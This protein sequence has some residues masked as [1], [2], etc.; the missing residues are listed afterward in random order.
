MSAYRILGPGVLSFVHAAGCFAGLRLCFSNETSKLPLGPGGVL[1]G[2]GYG[3]GTLYSVNPLNGAVTTIGN[4]NL[5]YWA[6]GST[7]SGLFALDSSSN[8]N[9]YSI[10]PSTGAA[11]FIGPTG[12]SRSAIV[13]GMSTGSSALYVTV[14]SSLYTLNLVTGAVGTSSSGLFGP[15]VLEAGTLFSGAADPSAIWTLN[16]SNGAGTF[17]TNVSGADTNFWG[18]A[19][20]VATP[21]PAALPLF[22]TGL[23]SL[24]LLGWRRKRKAQS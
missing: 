14:N 8:M 9:L 11:T 19:P 6:T 7:T 22:A 15:T 24:G 13:E 16:L 3:S 2:G 10:N 20:D 12:L 4:G 1:Y 21:L 23:G 5:T 18:L 17:V